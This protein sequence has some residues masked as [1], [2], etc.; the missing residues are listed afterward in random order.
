MKS[1]V[2]EVDIYFSTVYKKLL[3]A[4]F[5]K[6][7]K[8]IITVRMRRKQSRPNCFKVYSSNIPCMLLTWLKRNMKV[9]RADCYWQKCETHAHS[10]IRIPLIFAP[11]IHNKLS[12][13]N[14]TRSISFMT[15]THTHQPHKYA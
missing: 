2:N 10:S 5:F 4:S 12:N 9:E 11:H 7:P 15:T 14:S 3:T 6:Q 13:T 1:C 8:I